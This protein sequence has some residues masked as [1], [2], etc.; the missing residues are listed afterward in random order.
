MGSYSPTVFYTT[1]LGQKIISTIIE[2]TIIAMARSGNPFQGILYAGLM[3]KDNQPKLLEYNV[4]FGDP[5][6]QVILPR[7]NSDFL[8]IILGVVN[9]NLESVRPVW[10]T[11][12]CVGVVLASG[13]YPGHYKTGLPISGLDKLEKDLLVFQAGTTPGQNGQILT[14]GGRVLT[15]VSK[16]KTTDEA[17]RKIYDNISK[18][19]FEGMQYRRDIAKL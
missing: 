11:D 16:G 13:G 12:A 6:C 18:I 2:P 1:E 8:D 19:K 17:R 7:L 4:R 5:E 14:N 10:S 9:K 3:V 15:V